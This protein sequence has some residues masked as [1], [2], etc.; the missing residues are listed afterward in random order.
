MDVEGI[1]V[2]ASYECVGQRKA[3]DST[4]GY[5]S[6]LQVHADV[7]RIASGEHQ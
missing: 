1:V 7:T 3:F 6:R 2:D 4:L 5:G